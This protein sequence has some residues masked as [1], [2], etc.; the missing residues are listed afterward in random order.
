[1]CEK[2]VGIKKKRCLL[3]K[4]LTVNELRGLGGGVVVLS[5]SQ[6]KTRSNQVENELHLEVGTSFLSLHLYLDPN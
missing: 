2:E 1:M 5:D 3:Q 6:R 4:D